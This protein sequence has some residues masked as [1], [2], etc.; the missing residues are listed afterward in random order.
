[1][2]QSGE[3]VLVVGD[4]HIGSRSAGIPEKFKKMLV[5]NKMQHVLCKSSLFLFLCFFLFLIDRYMLLG[6]GNLCT[7]F[8]YEFLRQIAPNVHVV[9]GDMDDVSFRLNSFHSLFEDGC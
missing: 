2:A 5:P 6:T 1:M 7:K 4:M 8:E 9:R 3:L